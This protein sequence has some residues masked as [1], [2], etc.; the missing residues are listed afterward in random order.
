[1][2]ILSKISKV[3][4][5]QY[6][7]LKTVGAKQIRTKSTQPLELSYRIHGP[8][9]RPGSVPIF[10]LH[11]CLASKKNWET[12]CHKLTVPTNM[13]VIAADARNHGDS[14]HH[15]SHG[16]YDQA[17]DVSHLL[18]KFSVEKGIFIGHGMGGRTA[19][20]LALTQPTKVASMVVVD[21]SPVSTSC[22]LADFYPKTIDALSTMDFKGM[23]INTAEQTAK[24]K[25]IE[26][27]LFQ[28]E[29][30]LDYMLMNVGKLKNR[31]YGWKYNL[32]ALRKNVDNIV[33]FPK[34]NK[35][36][37]PG[38]VLFLG[39]KL[40]FAIPFEDMPGILKIFPRAQILYIDGAGHNAHVDQPQTFY[41]TVMQFLHYN[42]LMQTA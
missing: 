3:R 16:Y 38:P 41:D 6:T 4:L 32:G 33:S 13:T 2:D 18:T 23:N 25:M 15:S 1:M 27:N 28:T 10:V 29:K 34:L 8:S 14:P 9:P 24:N 21:I 30:E 35:K 12:F 22:G 19:M 20:V 37:Y 11:D 42:S 7:G 36:Q 39:G 40:S 5:L 31:T 17:A 26:N